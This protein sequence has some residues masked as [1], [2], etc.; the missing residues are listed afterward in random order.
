MTNQNISPV[1]FLSL[2]EN[3][4]REIQFPDGPSDQVIDRVLQG[5]GSESLERHPS[6][7][8]VPDRRVFRWNSYL[9]SAAAVLSLAAS[10]AII[11]MLYPRSSLAFHD[12]ANAIRNAKTLTYTVISEPISST[13]VTKPKPATGQWQ[14]R[15]KD[16]GL[17]RTDFQDGSVSIMDHT[18][19]EMIFLSP[20]LKT[21]SRTV[22]Q[23]GNLTS[24]EVSQSSFPIQLFENGQLHGE[25][26]GEKRINNR[27]VKGFE[28]QSGATKMKV[29]GDPETKRPVQIEYQ[30]EIPTGLCNITMQD[31]VFD[32]EIADELFSTSIPSGYAINEQSFPKV[33]FSKVSLPPES[34]VVNILK[35]YSSRFD[36]KFPKQIDDPGLIA[37]ILSSYSSDLEAGKQA[38]AELVPSMGASW[39]FRVALEKFGYS[40][41][42]M[43]GDA[44]KIIFWYLPKAA[45]QYRVVFGDLRIGDVDADQIPMSKTK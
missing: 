29:W 45:K 20:L 32:S 41:D 40:N 21:A 24:Q 35:L 7:R 5:I 16:P 18:K 12:L 30:V 25:S 6:E 31:F 22:M 34:H 28:V 23:T 19:Q 14:V 9:S 36:G 8:R 43:H 42:G 17:S 38:L 10:I 33:D 1:D 27:L 11:M 2:A 15:Y 13:E 44:D 4:M 3:A 37:A 39:T 26:L